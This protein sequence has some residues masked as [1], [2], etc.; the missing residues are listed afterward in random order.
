MMVWGLSLT[1]FMIS[2]RSPWASSSGVGGSGRFGGPPCWLELVAVPSVE[3]MPIP[4]PGLVERSGLM[5]KQLSRSRLSQ[6]NPLKGNSQWLWWIAGQQRSIVS[7]SIVG[8]V[9]FAVRVRC[10]DRIQRIYRLIVVVIARRRNLA[11][12][13]CRRWLSAIAARRC[14]RLRLWLLGRD[15]QFIKLCS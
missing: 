1:R 3:R 6:N 12:R 13:G 14:L 7:R 15:S 4:P 2:V 11:S 9:R 5:R 10:V 8:L